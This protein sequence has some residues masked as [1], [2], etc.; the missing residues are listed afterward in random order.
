M[1]KLKKQILEIV[2]IVKTC[3]PNLQEKCFEM[4]LQSAIQSNKL[5]EVK[6]S[7]VDIDEALETPAITPVVNISSGAEIEMK[8][9]HTKAKR[10]VP[11]DL[12]L[13]EIN[14]IFY[15]ENGDF[16][17]LY[18]DLKSPKI[19]EAQ[20]RVALMEA[21]K[22]GLKTGDFSFNVQ[23]IRKLCETYKCYD[24]SNF[25]ANFKT[26]KQ[27]FNEDYTTNGNMSLT[28]KGKEE[29]VKIAKELAK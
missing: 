23:T 4:L 9:L 21:L 13:E 1:D 12:S 6:V 29:M 19:A 3:P 5:P 20:I 24:G 11:K 8:D 14:N 15:K 22:N 2:E 26:N 16:L 27:N 18:D 7:K 10:F 28:S 17:P 25:A